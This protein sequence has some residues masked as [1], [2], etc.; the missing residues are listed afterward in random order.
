MQLLANNQTN[1]QSISALIMAKPGDEQKE[2]ARKER[3]RARDMEREK[4][5]ETERE[6]LTALREQLVKTQQLL[7]TAKQTQHMSVQLEQEKQARQLLELQVGSP[8]IV[9]PFSSSLQLQMAKKSHEEMAAQHK[10]RLEHVESSAMILAT[11]QAQEKCNAKMLEAAQQ[12]EQTFREGGDD[13]SNIIICKHETN[14]LHFKTAPV[15][16][17]PRCHEA[18]SSA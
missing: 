6:K 12:R 17:T 5:R 3:E 15:Y 11:A 9:P 16:P 18:R 14:L 1:T 4:E 8:C 2:R 10:T 13:I 7:E